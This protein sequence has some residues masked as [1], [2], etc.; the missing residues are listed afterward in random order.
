MRTAML[1]AIPIS[2]SQRSLS[3][4]FVGLRKQTANCVSQAKI[5]RS[6]IPGDLPC[7]P[8]ESQ[9][10]SRG[11]IGDLAGD[12]HGI[13][14]LSPLDLGTTKKCSIALVNTFLGKT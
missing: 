6:E 12:T 10:I 13:G 8:R 2:G 5:N 7:D 9:G 1:H 14:S 4:E 11:L 3:S